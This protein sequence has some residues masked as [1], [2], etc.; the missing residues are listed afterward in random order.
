MRWIAGVVVFALCTPASA[1]VLRGKVVHVAD[2]DTITVL[3]ADKVQHKIRLDDI[4]A[5]EKTQAFGTKSKQKLSELVGEKEVIVNW[6]K[7]DRYDRI[8]GQVHLGRRDINL[9]MVEAGLAWH[10]K[11]Y[12]K[13]Q[14]FAD[15]EHLARQAHRGLWVDKSPEPPWEF[16]KRKHPK[17]QASQ[18]SVAG[19]GRPVR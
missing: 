13:D 11:Q 10:Y 5:P 16:R 4:D 9:E 18:E 19:A 3:T 6:K 2:G 14:T 1:E 12:S 7:K 8:L 15:A 17:T